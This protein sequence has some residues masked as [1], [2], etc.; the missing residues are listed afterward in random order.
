MAIGDLIFQLMGQ[1]DPRTALLQAAQGGA[2]PQATPPAAGTGAPAA[3]PSQP[4]Q[5]QAYQSPPQV[6]ELYM[7]LMKRQEQNRQIDR[8][9]GLIGSSLA[10]EENRP[11]IMAAFMG[12]S[13]GADPASL[14]NT[15]LEFQSKQG[16]MAQK[17]A[18]R[19][20]VP[21]IA[22]K[23]GLDVATAQYL[24]DTGKLDSVIAEAEKPDNQIV[25]NPDG[26]FNIVD[27]KSGS[28]GEVFGT[29]KPRDIEIVTDDNGN[30]FSVYKDTGERVGDK[31]IVQGSGSTDDIKEWNEAGRPGTLEQ[32][33]STTRKSSNPKST[34]NVGP[35]GT[36][37]ADPPK[38]MAWKRD[39][40]GNIEINPETKL[41]IAVPVEGGPVDAERKSAEANAA[42]LADSKAGTADV[43]TE[44]IDRII[45]MIEDPANSGLKGTT[46]LA[47]T[48]GQYIPG[49][50]A[51]D[52]S[53]LA[54]TVRANIGFDKLQEMRAA[55]PTGAALGPVSDF[56]NRLLQ[57][58]AGN[59]ELPQSKDQVLFNLRRVRKLYEK[60]TTG[61][62]IKDQKE[63]DAFFK[64][65]EGEL[66]KSDAPPAE[67]TSIDDLLKKYGG[68]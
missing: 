56:E 36:E 24:F 10:F 48:I 7:N 63:A 47:A 54:D 62:G 9:I 29:P 21:S 60:I 39:A 31:N 51:F 26:T 23:Y 3:A 19:A 64:Q 68:Q 11:G 4:P 61:G 52:A 34:A 38:D 2:Q 67:D 20:T 13:G 55:S 43:V 22:A 17:A 57:A 12:D 8:G 41:P 6:M 53:R 33:I 66:K 65:V 37:Y 30:K 45:G 18:Q 46:G 40:T 15:M 35:D 14:V 42:T 5:P 32:W 44:D 28:V 58:T 49:H 50:P 16:A 27:K 1:Q 59:L 25:N